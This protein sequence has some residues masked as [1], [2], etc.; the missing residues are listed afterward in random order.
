MPKFELEL[1]FNFGPAADRDAENTIL[2]IAKKLEDAQKLSSG[3]AIM[4]GDILVSCIIDIDRPPAQED[5]A[6][7]RERVLK[8]FIA[9]LLQLR[10]EDRIKSFKN[11]TAEKKYL[12]DELAK[13]AGI[14]K[15]VAMREIIM[16]SVT[17]NDVLVEDP[18]ATLL[19][20]PGFPS[21]I[22]CRGK[23]YPFYP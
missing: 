2:N 5:I 13:C 19:N 20:E 16:G 23:F 14:D 3:V 6:Y 22:G 8:F 12:V 21:M 17:V 7:H 18:A 10:R 15:S 1:D 4:S 11:T 9:E